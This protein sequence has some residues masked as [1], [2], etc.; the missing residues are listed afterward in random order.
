MSI[1]EKVAELLALPEHD[2]AFI[3]REL[4]TSLNASV[5]SETEAEWD[6]VIERRSQE[7]ENGEVRCRPTFPKI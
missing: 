3:A 5:D 1:A 6:E 2:R 4:I 7:I